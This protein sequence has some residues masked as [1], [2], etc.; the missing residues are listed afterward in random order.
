MNKY[1]CLVLDHDDTLVRSTPTIHYPSFVEALKQLRPELKPY[2]LEE[3]VS[4]CF[5][6]GFF[7]MCDEILKFTEEE[8]AIQLDLWR[9]HTSNKIPPLYDGFK[10]LIRRF[11]SNGGY[12]CVVS[13]SESEQIKKHYQALLGFEPDLT[14]GCDMEEDKIKPNPFPL[15]DI[16]ERLDLKPS[17]LLMV[18]DLK[19]GLDMAKTCGVDFAS[20]GWSHLTDEMINYMKKHSD[21]YFTDVEMLSKLVFNE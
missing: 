9:Q 3:F 8:R 1:K 19:P 13:H 16:M 6:P 2:T 10:D 20:A 14:Y 21:Y 12:I 18:D 7:V 4:Y 15:E 11:K 5:S 17:E